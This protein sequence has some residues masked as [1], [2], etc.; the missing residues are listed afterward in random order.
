MKRIYI[1]F[2]GAA[3]DP[4]TEKVAA[5]YRH[6]GADEFV[7]YDD[8]W[9]LEQPFYELNKWLWTFP[10]NRVAP[11]RG[12]PRGF[13]W[14]CWKPFIIMHALGQAD[15]GD[16][17][18]YVDG[19]THP[20]APIAPLYEEC[21]RIGGL[22]LFEASGCGHAEYCKRDCLIVMGQDEDR[23]R[24]TQA[25]V[26]RFMLFQKGPWLAHQFLI[27]WLAYCLNPLA[28]TFEPSV[29][30]PEY[31]EYGEHRTEQAIMTNLAHKHRIKLYREA[32]QFG[33]GWPA[34]TELYGQV[35]RQVGC[36]AA[37][38]GTIDGSRYR[39]V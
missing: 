20:I 29:L 17:V 28:Q 7:V 5:T 24:K 36:A 12:H 10:E 13:G 33:E 26:A 15:I 18:L 16:I 34:D 30:A 14:F 25:G 23:Y 31:P 2:S 8:R 9:L 32:C 39:N 11:E 4:I 22:M 6:Y 38:T 37:D 3:Y 27:E 35:F 1:T 21:A 19:D